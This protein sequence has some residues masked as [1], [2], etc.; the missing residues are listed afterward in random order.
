[1]GWTGTPGNWCLNLRPGTVSNGLNA[2]MFTDFPPEGSFK[3]KRIYDVGLEIL[4]DSKN[5]FGFQWSDSPSL[6][7][8]KY[9]SVVNTFKFHAF[10]QTAGHGLK[11]TE[12][13]AEPSLEYESVFRKYQA[14]PKTNL[15]FLEG[16]SSHTSS[17]FHDTFSELSDSQ[18]FWFFSPIF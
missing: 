3:L 4:S 15:F 5:W 11:C 18:T 6:N 13:F 10:D 16:T 9:R 17:L 12:R 8:L 1:M 7:V 2:E 14:I